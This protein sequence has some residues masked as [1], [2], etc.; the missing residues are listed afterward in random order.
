MGPRGETLRTVHQSEFGESGR[1]GETAPVV[2]RET[3][4]E[5][6]PGEWLVSCQERVAL[7]VFR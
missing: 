6:G 2:G 3:D 7:L 1:R 4:R 5:I